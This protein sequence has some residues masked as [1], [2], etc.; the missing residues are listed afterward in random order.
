MNHGYLLEASC[1]D[2]CNDTITYVFCGEIRKMCLVEK[3]C[4]VWRMPFSLVFPNFM[5]KCFN[6]PEADYIL[7]CFFVVVFSSLLL[8]LFS[9][10]MGLI[11]HAIKLFLGR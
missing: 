6:A 3:K 1:S 5:G 2:N 11:F 4:L 7:K 10:K 9:E 8:L